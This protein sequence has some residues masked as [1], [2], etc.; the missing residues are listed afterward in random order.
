MRYQTQQK[1]PLNANREESDNQW[2]NDSKILRDE[3]GKFH[4]GNGTMNSLHFFNYYNF[5]KIE[6]FG[7]YRSDQLLVYH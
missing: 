2:D 7:S 4:N 6:K 1:N 5:L 3:S